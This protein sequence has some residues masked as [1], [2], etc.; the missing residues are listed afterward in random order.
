[1]DIN[2][3]KVLPHEF[4]Y[5]EPFTEHLGCVAV[6][7]GGDVY[8]GYIDH[9]GDFEILP[10]F[11]HA[12]PFNEG[13]AL[14]SNDDDKWFVIDKKGKAITEAIYTSQSTDYQDGNCIAYEFLRS[15]N[16]RGFL[17]IKSRT[18][19]YNCYQIDRSGN[20][21]LIDEETTQ[22]DHGDSIRAAKLDFIGMY[23]EKDAND[24]RI[25]GY[26]KI[27]ASEYDQGVFSECGNYANKGTVHIQAKYRNAGCFYNG[28]A[29]VKLKSGKS[30][31]IDT[32]GKELFTF[33]DAR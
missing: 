15:V 6:L 1:M 14:V 30:A 28:Y 9:Y 4:V 25:Y 22:T 12:R 33:R 10:V 16:R 19:F 5:A 3:D 24:R 11:K 21:T 13:R 8:Y 31:Y 27:D 7:K 26:V 17:R 29:R 18:T 23:W 32:K 20:A 2:G